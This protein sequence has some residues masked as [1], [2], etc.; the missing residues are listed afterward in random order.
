MEAT[1]SKKESPKET[2]EK[3]RKKRERPAAQ[4]KKAPAFFYLEGREAVKNKRGEVG[5]LSP[6]SGRIKTEE[7][8]NRP[9]EKRKV[10]DGGK[11]EGTIF[12]RGKGGRKEKIAL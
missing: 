12:R 1:H 2:E 9:G 8:V 4:K 5:M 7:L 6:A 11:S 10:T 3:G